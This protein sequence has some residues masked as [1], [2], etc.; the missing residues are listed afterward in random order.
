MIGL[1]L[2]LAAAT[3]SFVL[4]IIEKK[5][6]KKRKVVLLLSTIVFMILLGQQFLDYFSSKASSKIIENISSRTNT[7][8]TTTRRI[9]TTIASIQHLLLE[10]LRNKKYW[11]VGVEVNTINDLDMLGAFD[12]GTSEAWETY[13]RWLSASSTGKKGLRITVNDNRH[14]QPELLLLYLVTN[15]N[16][17]NRLRGINRRH[18]DF[19]DPSSQDNLRMYYDFQ[20]GCDFVLFQDK[21]GHL[22]GFAR[23]SEFINDLLAIYPTEQIGS[24][25][26]YINSPER[27][28][29]EFARRYIPSFNES[30]SGNDIKSIASDM[31][32]KNL[33]E[34]ISKIDSTSVY[35]NISTILKTN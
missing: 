3:I 16:N 29:T 21:T 11:E 15:N 7:I 33:G 8:D 2:S 26:M 4:L 22:K 9:D 28:F 13:T 30:A 25:N 5:E 1:I 27:D 6:D 14:Y 12:K 20:P 19:M 32:R 18:S 23:T 34:T 24:F 35:L 31:I 10:K 17:K